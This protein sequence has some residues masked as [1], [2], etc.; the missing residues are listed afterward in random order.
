MKRLATTHVPY[1]NEA[2]VKLHS[3]EQEKMDV[4]KRMRQKYKIYVDLDFEKH[5][6]LKYFEYVTGGIESHTRTHIM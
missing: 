6:K 5:K 2:Y 4:Q 1:V 3:N